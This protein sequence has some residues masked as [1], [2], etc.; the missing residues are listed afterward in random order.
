M[1]K[2]VERRDIYATV[3][4]QIIADM[5]RGVMPW[6]KPWRNGVSGDLSLLPVSAA[7]GR[8]YSGV[9]ILLLWSALRDNGYTDNRWMTFQQARKVDACVRKGE[10]GTMIVYAD[11]F[12]P[13]S[14]RA[15]ASAEGRE[16]RS[17]WFLKSHHVFNVSQIDGLPLD[18]VAAPAPLSTFAHEIARRAPV[19]VQHGGNRAFYSPARDFIQM[20]PIE[21]FD[22]ETYYA[23]TLAHEMVHATGHKSRLDRA[24]GKKFGDKGYA[25]EELV[26]ELGA[27]FLCAALSGEYETRHADYVANWLSVLREDSRAIV[28]AAS[29][30][31]KAVDYLM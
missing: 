20:P 6:S 2:T 23:Q 25:R 26:A 8:A 19:T 7:T 21:A 22:V 13:A 11:K 4:N 29:A 9:N 27:A 14:E 30:A 3:T 5:E 15:K 28:Q 10:R 12:V 17:S 31:S 1:T 16:E 18:P 24:F